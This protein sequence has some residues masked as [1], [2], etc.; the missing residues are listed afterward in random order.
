MKLSRFTI[1]LAS[2]CSFVLIPTAGGQPAGDKIAA[3]TAE[4]AKLL[5]QYT[6]KQRTAV[7]YKGEEKFVRV[8]QVKL[9]PDGKRQETV[10]SEKPKNR[11]AGRSGGRS[12]TTSARK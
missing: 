3:N 6:W 8:K 10:L 7:K 9:D 12:R 4:N 2:V 11:P 1:L 5:R